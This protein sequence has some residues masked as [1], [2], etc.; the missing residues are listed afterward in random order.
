MKR[1]FLYIIILLLNQFTHEALSQIISTSP[2]PNSKLHH[3]ETSVLIKFASP[4]YEVSLNSERFKMTGT[5]S[6]DLEINYKLSEDKKSIILKSDKIFDLGETI[7]VNINSGIILESG[8]NVDATEFSFQIKEQNAPKSS[9]NNIKS[10][11]NLYSIDNFPS[12]TINVN[13]N[14]AEGRIFF[15]NISPLESDNDRFYAIMENDGTPFFAK[16]DNHKGLNFNLQKNGYLTIWDD[17]NFLMLDSAYNVIKTFECTNG[18]DADWHELQVLENGHAFLI[19]YDQ[20]I[21]DM[22]TIVPGG[23]ES[24]IVEG[25]IIQEFDKQNNLVFQWRSWD[26]LDITDA[27]NT[28]FTDLFVYYTHGNA[29]E[30]DYDGNILVSV[31]AMNQIIKIDRNTG[32]IIWRLGGINSDFTFTNDEGFCRQHDI[33]RISNGNI[34]L[35]DNGVCHTP[36]IS[37][38]KEYK[39]DEVNKTAT[40]VWEYKHPEEI[41]CIAMGNVQRLS[42]GNTFINWGQLPIEAMQGDDLWPSITEVR[43]DKSIAYE[44]TFNE[45]YHLIYRSYRYDWDVA[46]ISTSNDPQPEL[47]KFELS[48]FPN[49]SADYINLSFNT[50]ISRTIDINILSASGVVVKRF[51]DTYI[52]PNNIVNIKISELNQGVYFCSVLYNNQLITKRFVIIK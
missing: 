27:I 14:P 49:P 51:H 30:I 31:L 10:E 9:L 46:P 50:E 21:F 44:V 19:A 37:R 11:Q 6:G 22:S 25:I 17:R 16:Q 8:Y 18:Y 52:D 24:A 29:I 38:A 40:L 26:H 34:T 35:Y 43:P 36:Q 41:F 3:S 33:R 1:F 12:L 42:N 39:L 2:V 20:Q 47:E 23:R 45:F 5:T 28:V 15:Y 13:D 48:I 7:T 4:V 32:D